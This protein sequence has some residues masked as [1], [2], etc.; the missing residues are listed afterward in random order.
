MVVV[1]EEAVAVVTD[2]RPAINVVV[3]KPVVDARVANSSSTT[4]NSQLYENAEVNSD[5]KKVT[6]KCLRHCMSYYA[7]DQS[8]FKSHCLSLG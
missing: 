1:E 3:V 8:Y 5:I 2:L 4:T 7:N 6:V